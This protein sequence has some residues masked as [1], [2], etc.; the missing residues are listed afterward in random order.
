MLFRSINHERKS[1]A[2]SIVSIVT[3]HD[4]EAYGARDLADIL[5]Q[6]PG[7][8]FG[9]DVYS[10]A[11]LSFRGIWVEEGKALLMIDGITQN[12]LGYGTF[13]YFGSIPASMIERVEIIRGPGSAIY[14]GFAEAAVINVVTHQPE[15]LNGARVS[16]D[17]GA[18]GRGG[19]SRFGNVV[20]GTQTDAIRVSGH[21][22]YGSTLLSTREYADFFGNRLKL[23][24]DNAYRQWQHIITEASAK[25]LTVRYQ[26]NSFTYG[27]QDAFTTIQP[28]VNGVNA[29]RVNNYNEVI[30]LDYAAKLSDTLTLQPLFEY[31]RNNSWSFPLASSVNAM[32]EGAST[33]MWRSHAEMTLLYETP[34]AAH[35][36]LGGG[37]VRDGIESVAAD[38]TPGLQLSDN[39]N[40]LGSQKSAAS[41]YCLFQYEQQMGPVGVTAGGRYEDTI[42]GKAFAPRTGVTY[43]HEAFNAK[44]LYGEAFRIPTL[45][46]AFSREFT[47]NADLKPD[48][49]KTTEMELGYKFGDHVSGTVN[50]FHIDIK[51]PI[52]F[53][54]N[55]NSYRN[56]GR[57]RSNGAEAELRASY[58]RFG[59]FANL[60]YAAPGRG[61]AGGF[62]TQ[63]NRQFLSNPP[64][65][66]NLGTYYRAGR[67]E[68]APSATYLAQRAG[69]SQESANDPNG[70]LGTTGYAPL[71]LANMNIVA[72]DVFKGFDIHLAVH[73]VFDTHYL[74]VQPYYG[75]HSPM[76]AQDREIDLGFTWRL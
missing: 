12:E 32:F 29:E 37:Y 69:Q 4:I 57:L 40:D 9:L 65:K 43:V 8:D 49:A 62:V 51:D 10:E 39:V 73:N 74:L 60:A 17:A 50:I 7:F 1:K 36:R 23:N 31:T 71:V 56:F 52:V 64:L 19:S 28:P 20:F 3:R 5:R 42:F 35:A 22:G 16:G 45:W 75:A 18:V 30:H 54:G 27:G 24:Q 11:A 41:T 68:F 66:I 72:H 21:V 44:V 70:Q 67:F 48:R 46:Q 61:T 13:N 76:P 58:P 38:G 6:A 14:G 63:S 33:L 55:T 26:R 2:P 47:F 15:N 59:G 34:W 53:Q 25:N